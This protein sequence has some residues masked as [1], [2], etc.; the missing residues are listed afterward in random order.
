MKVSRSVSIDT[1]TL[2]WFDK[3]GYNFSSLVNRLIDGFMQEKQNE[4]EKLK[5]DIEVA[6][7]KL[8]E[9]EA[10]AKQKLEE[11]ELNSIENKRIL[12][13]AKRL[14]QEKQD[15]EI[16]LLVEQ[17][18]P[19]ADSLVEEQRKNPAFINDAQSLISSVN[20]FQA[21]GVRVGLVQLKRYIT[22]KYHSQ[23]P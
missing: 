23:Q 21:T 2:E 19:L 14:D 22:L 12:E 13:E 8:Q 10:K 3:K 16:I 4:T 9:R 20:M 1:E 15:K 17:N 5:H 6:T 7:R 18:Q 11:E